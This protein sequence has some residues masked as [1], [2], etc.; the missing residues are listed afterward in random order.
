MPGHLKSN[1][2]I[3]LGMATCLG[4]AGCAVGPDYHAPNIK[5]P[6]GF[7]TASVEGQNAPKPDQPVIDATFWWK[8]LND[9]QLDSL[10]DRAIANNP[11]L[12]IALDRVQE[13]RTQEEVVLGGALP[14]AGLSASYANGTGSDLTKGRADSA[15][16]SGDNS[17]GFSKINGVAGFA[18]SYELDLF[19]KYRRELE[20][21]DYDTQATIA[22]HNN[23]LVSVIAD[24]ARAYVDMRSEQMQAAVLQKNIG[25][26]NNYVKLTQE[27]YDRGITNELDLTLAQ[28][29][30]ATLEADK[31]PLSAQIRAAQYV[32]ATL[33]GQFPEE[34][35]KELEKPGLVPFLPDNIQTGLPL[36]LLRRRPDIQEAERNAAEA[37]AGI[38]VAEADLFPQVSLVGG[39]GLQG[40]N[41]IGLANPAS[42]IWSFGPSVSWSILDFGTLN[43]LVDKAD[44]HTKEMLVQYKKTVLGAV[45]EVDTSLDAYKAQQDRL[46]RLGQALGASKKAVD[47][48][49]QRY[50]RGLTDSLNVID[51][52]RQEYTLEAQYETAQQ[53]AAEQF[54]GLYKALGGGWE[55]YQIFP[56]LRQP[57]PDVI[58]A[59][60]SLVETHDLSNTPN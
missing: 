40:G 4:L 24:V 6:D 38:G 20:A 33:C 49:T 16:R 50:N 44:L 57:L 58:A 2:F 23:V 31:A 60:A 14:E 7:A 36:D 8:S 41:R 12:E 25:N 56:P 17:A 10:I 3:L 26:L 29:Q 45:R 46:A 34:L 42:F 22:A 43:A 51:A 35:T 59:F 54:I 30:L 19:G 52:E 39:A 48:S 37:T 55:P 28:R 9:P 1:R 32:I 47:L 11:D 13:A 15:L 53:I 18:S 5:M 27:R 21:A